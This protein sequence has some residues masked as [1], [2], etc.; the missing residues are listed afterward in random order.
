MGLR[1]GIQVS[2]APLSI[3]NFRHGQGNGWQCEDSLSFK[4]NEAQTNEYVG[5]IRVSG[6]VMV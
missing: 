5:S 6:Q 4:L 3:R 2:G 1:F